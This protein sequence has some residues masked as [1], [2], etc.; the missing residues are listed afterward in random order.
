MARSIVSRLTWAYASL[1][2]AVLLLLGGLTYAGLSSVLEQQMDNSLL[3]TARSE[4]AYA[5]DHA[6]AGV[7]LHDSPNLSH[8]S[9]FH[10][11]VQITDP[12]GRVIAATHDLAGQGLPLDPAALA[13]NQAGKPA[14]RSRQMMGLPHRILYYPIQHGGRQYS[15][16][17]AVSREYLDLVEQQLLGIFTALSLFGLLVA[18]GLGY[19][20]A[21]RA[22]APVRQMTETAEAISEST[23]SARMPPAP[24]ADELGRLTQVLNR[25]LDRLERAFDSQR[26]F[27]SD[28]AHELRSPLAILKGNA[29]FALR[30]DRT[31][32]EHRDL[33]QSSD[34]EIDRL[35]KLTNDLLQIAQS[36][37]AGPP[38]PRHPIPIDPLVADAVERHRATANQ[39][40]IRL[41]TDLQAGAT[42]IGADEAQLVQVVDNLVSNA[43]RYTPAGKGV[44]VRTRMD[45]GRLTLAVADEGIGIA[46]ADQ[47]KVFDRFYRTDEARARATGGAGLGLSICRVL[48]EQHGGTIGVTSTPGEGSVFSV[49]LPAVVGTDHA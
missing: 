16:Q 14:F 20:L 9:G 5:T 48:V 38:P 22:I 41:T 33:W 45:D 18:I 17:V 12:D 1:T 49:T 2:A 34:E 44:Q 11:H 19:S 27:V 24:V 36:D 4:A 26:R 6:G 35:T 7:H 47:P 21:R 25:M 28:A 42:L 29:E 37:A 32:E 30:R 39:A 13:V 40:G 3:A 46:P 8:P 43:L 10:H 23:L 31:A 15:L